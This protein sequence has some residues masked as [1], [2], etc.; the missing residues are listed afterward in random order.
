MKKIILLLF[1]VLFIFKSFPCGNY[2]FALNKEGN[3]IPLGYDWKFPFSKNFSPELNVQKLQK[4]EKKLRKEKNFMLLSDYSLCLM[5]LGKSKEAAEILKE[6]Y[7]HYPNEYKIAANLGTAYE[8]IGENDSAL[9]YI[10]RGIQL[11]PDD[12]EG[13]E[14][15]HAKIL[16]T[17]LEL[18]KNPAFLS[19]HSVLQLSE[20]QKKDS[21]VFY[22]LSIQLKERFPFTPGPDPIMASLMAD[23]GDLSY[24]VKSI[25]YAKAYYQIAK[26]YYGNTNP[27]L[28]M[29]IKEISKLMKKYE[30]VKPERVDYFEGDRIKIHGINYKDLI[31]E[32][33][34]SNY[35][36]NW[37]KINANV[38]SLLALVDFTK[39]V[40]EIVY[41]E[42]A[43]TIDELKLIPE[44]KDSSLNKDTATKQNTP[45]SIILRKPLPGEYNTMWIYGAV[46]FLVLIGVIF[47]ILKKKTK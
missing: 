23:L 1:F 36:V 32:N 38:D 2:Y 43:T 8:L 45:P 34:E 28:E 29:K 5:K 15:I 46:G 13:S 47:L 24:N 17:K 33:N 27:E 39:T 14:W 30:T 19:S 18:K 9:K 12:H 16:E 44:H 25:E 10:K 21:V 22:H 42:S 35:K 3:L 4:L 11:N 6:L 31:S 41:K 40:T 20:K 26:V 7:L 37:D